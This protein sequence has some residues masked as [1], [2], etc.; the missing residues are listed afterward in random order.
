M[1]DIVDILERK[2]EELVGE[3]GD[4]DEISDALYAAAEV[5]V[6]G[7]ERT[8]ADLDY[9]GDQ[10]E[11]TVEENCDDIQGMLDDA[12]SMFLAMAAL[13]AAVAV[14][15]LP[16]AWLGWAKVLF[17]ISGLGCIMLLLCWIIFGVTSSTYTIV[18]DLCWAMEDYLENPEGSDL[19]SVMPCMDKQTSVETMDEARRAIQE[20]LHDSNDAFLQ[21]GDD[22]T[23]DLL[24]EYFRKMDVSDLCVGG[25]EVAKFPEDPEYVTLQCLLYAEERGGRDWKA[26]PYEGE[27][28]PG[29][30]N[31]VLL[32]DFEAYYGPMRCDEPSTGDEVALYQCFQDGLMMPADIYDDA[33]KSAE[34]AAT[35]V[36]SIP[37]IESLIRCDIVVE[38]FEEITD[39]TCDDMTNE[40][41]MLWVGFM[42]L[43][44]GYTGL[45]FSWGLISKM[46][47]A[48]IQRS[49]SGLNPDEHTEADEQT[50]AASEKTEVTNT[51]GDYA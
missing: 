8:A 27:Y 7:M 1:S 39:G 11:T 2:A 18:S 40:I 33:A 26:Y 10:L 48:G 35:V 24:T 16:V 38:T 45:W 23:A 49:K 15:G 50:W 37:T 13:L 31:S 19:S 9:S 21:I 28:V 46:M 14:I 3:G 36:Q 34:S 43:A 30:R 47:W 42:C 4:L 5:G 17:A 29:D 41:M 12:A 25:N 20:I 32:E 6:E 22:F 44:I 51:D